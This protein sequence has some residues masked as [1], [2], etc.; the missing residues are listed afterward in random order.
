[1]EFKKILKTNKKSIWKNTCEILV[2][3][4]TAWWSF[5]WNMEFL[6]NNKKEA[7]CHYV[8][9]QNFWEV[10]KIWEDT[11][12]LWHAWKSSWNWKT[13][14]NR[15]SIWIEIVNDWEKFSDIQRQNVDKLAIEL[16]KKYKIKK[17]NIVR[18]KD[19]APGRKNDPYDSLWNTRFKSFDD[20]KN[21]LF[22]NLEIMSKYTE[23]KEKVLKE[24]WVKPIF[25]SCEWAWT[26]T[27]Q[28]TK[29][30]IEIAFARFTERLYKT[31]QNIWK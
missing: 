20:Y 7:S 21:Y 29:E 30:L 18:H 12:I 11:D 3:H 16:I 31:F 2:L 4:H 23:I 9:W 24:T 15:F 13:D 27:E 14:L 26:L 22:F 17:E 6:A 8:L 5:D 10:W 25:E 19:I 28:E 1:M